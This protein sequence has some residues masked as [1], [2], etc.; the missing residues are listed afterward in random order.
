MNYSKVTAIAHPMEGLI[1]YHGLRDH[2]LRI[3]FHDSRSVNIEA[4]NTK[5]TVE[6]G[7]FDEDSFVIGGVKIRND[8]AQRMLSVI[9]TVREIANIKD[10]VKV[11]SENSISY[12]K[13]KGLGFSSSAGA[14]L[15]RAAYNAAGLDEKIGI[16]MKLLSRISRR[17]AGS[18]C[19]STVGGFSRWVAGTGDESSY[20]YRIENSKELDLTIIIVPV[21][22]SIKT[23]E[24][25]KEVMSSPFFDARVSSVFK[26][27]NEM[28]KAIKNGEFNKIGW[29][30]EIDSLEL[31][32]LTMTGENAKIVVTSKTLQIIEMVRNLRKKGI[33]AY[34]SMQTGPSVF[35][36]TQSESVKQ[37]EDKI[38]ELGFEYITSK[39]GGPTKII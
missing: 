4:L 19:R 10:K 14:A 16:D 8:N 36:N 13:A 30:S 38:K 17:L 32:A 7:E 35:I 29:L 20:A 27:V 11:E 5:T 15:A 6:F 2:E 21:Y 37:I 31:H 25:H 26:R 18:A 23:E 28:E 22:S 34:F 33:K 3:P 1:K 24:A 39:I 9:N 12:K